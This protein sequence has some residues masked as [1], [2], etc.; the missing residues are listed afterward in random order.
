MIWFTCSKCGKTHGRPENSIG[1][2]VF[3]ECGQGNRVPWEST[4]AEPPP[5]VVP[6]ALP[7]VPSTPTLAPL[8]FGSPSS[9]SD[10]PR[11]DP[12]D[13]RSDDPLAR[14]RRGGERR[15]PNY[16]FN[17]SAVLRTATCED[18]GESFC[19]SC[20]ATL[21]GANLCAPCKN[22]RVRA[23]ELPPRN[24]TAA[25]FSL[26]IALVTGSVLS[27]CLLPFGNNAAVS[28]LSLLTLLPQL[29]ALGLGIRALYLSQ[30]GEPRL[31]GQA[32]AVTGVSAAALCITLTLL[33]NLYGLRA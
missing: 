16:C 9:P 11:T 21:E 14:R 20:L 10:P 2:M 29:L 4:T 23:L 18:C 33:L 13:P 12:R 32:L 27:F 6:T 24:S 17:H 31:G 28:I 8:T 22:F 7:G 30:Q 3:C 19:A 5:Q 15:D 1:S 26:L 25:T